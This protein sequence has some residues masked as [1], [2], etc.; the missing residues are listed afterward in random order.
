MTENVLTIFK[1]LILFRHVKN[2]RDFSQNTN[3]IALRPPPEADQPVI[4]F[5]A[6]LL[7]S[8]NQTALCTVLNPGFGFAVG[9]GQQAKFSTFAF[10]KNY[11]HNSQSYMKKS[12]IKFTVTLDETK[13]PVAIDWEAQ[14]S[15]LEGVKSSKALMISLW[16]EKENST[17]RIDLWTKEMLVDEMHR[18]F[19]ESLNSMADTY[20]RATQDETMAKELRAFSERFITSPPGK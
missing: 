14:D 17:L 1:Y 7:Q 16:D 8:P 9:I 12:E 20:L 6:L 19:Y 18:F 3:A 13:Q 2:E 4:A 11:A 10:E 15:G 5:V